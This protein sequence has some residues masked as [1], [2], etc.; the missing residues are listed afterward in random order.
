MT[1]AL[2]AGSIL[3][4]PFDRR[5]EQFERRH[6]ARR[7]ERSLIDRVHPPGVS[8]QRAHTAC[9]ARTWLVAP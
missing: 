6:V 1:T 4:D 8:S 2:S 9:V 7:D 5:L 3:L